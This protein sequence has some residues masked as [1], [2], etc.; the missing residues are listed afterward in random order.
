MYS[1]GVYFEPTVGGEVRIF[2][3]YT[4]KQTKQKN[5]KQTNQNGHVRFH[6][7][8]GSAVRVVLGVSGLPYYLTPLVCGPDVLGEHAAQPELD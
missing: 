5:I 3:V 2:R 7:S 6:V 8:C 1:Q 4:N